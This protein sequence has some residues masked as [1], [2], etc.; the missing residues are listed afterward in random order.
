MEHLRTRKVTGDSVPP[1]PCHISLKIFANASARFP[2]VPIGFTIFTALF[3][4]PSV[5]NRENGTV[6]LRHC[7]VEFM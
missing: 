1:S 6:A 5:K 7:I 3:H 2:F 4:L